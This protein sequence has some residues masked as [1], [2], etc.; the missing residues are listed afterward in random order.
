MRWCTCSSGKL[1]DMLFCL[2]FLL[3]LKPNV[4]S[5]NLPIIATPKSSPIIANTELLKIGGRGGS[6]SMLKR[7]SGTRASF[8][9]IA[10]PCQK[11][12]PF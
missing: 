2:L 4:R 7:K 11:L 8:W 6:L 9:Y 1:I 5:I 10:V 3:S 12:L